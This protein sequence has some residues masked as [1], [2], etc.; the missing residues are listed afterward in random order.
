MDAVQRA[1]ELR[2]QGNRAFGEARLHDAMEAYTAA[3]ALQPSSST[4]YSNRARCLFQLGDFEAALQDAQRA[5]EEDLTNIKAHFLLGTSL[6]EM[7]KKSKNVQ[8]VDTAL[9][10]LR[11]AIGLCSSQNVRQLEN[12]LNIR[13]LRAQKLKWYLEKERYESE[14]AEAEQSFRGRVAADTTLSEEQRQQLLTDWSSLLNNRYEVKGVIPSYLCCPL[15]GQLFS[16]P[17]LLSSGN[18]FERATAAVRLQGSC[19]DPLTGDALATRAVAPNLNLRQAV[20]HFLAEN[21][22]AFERAE[23]DSAASISF[24]D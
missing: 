15:S 22:W 11:K 24:A 16:D 3:V 6:C 18:S 13:V 12:A 10:R 9:V 23:G 21:P 1:E 14:L 8:Q 20:A 19:C 2:Q 7:A 4:L 17:V 5:V